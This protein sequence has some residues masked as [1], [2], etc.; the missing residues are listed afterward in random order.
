MLSDTVQVYYFNV[1]PN[2]ETKYI[3]LVLT[4]TF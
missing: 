3:L 2:G 4:F 1:K